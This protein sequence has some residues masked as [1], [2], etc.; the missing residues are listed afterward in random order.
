MSSSDPTNGAVAAITAV[1]AVQ[2]AAAGAAAAPTKARPSPKAAA[3]Q[4]TVEISASSST[5]SVSA[6]VLLLTD[7]GQSPQAIA[8]LL[9]ITVAAVKS[10]LG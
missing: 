5:Q 1:S 3:P 8:A 6:Q 7:Q 9:G 2:P 4:D 10:Y